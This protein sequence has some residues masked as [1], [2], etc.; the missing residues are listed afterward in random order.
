MQAK[1]LTGQRFG[2]LVAIRPTKARSNGHIKWECRCDCGKTACIS[3]QDLVRGSTRSC[4]CIRREHASTLSTA[5]RD[6]IAEKQMQWIMQSHRRKNNTSGKCGVRIRQTK[7]GPRYLAELTFEGKR[8]F[9]KT[10]RTF[11]EAVAARERAEKEAYA[12][13]DRTVGESK[14]RPAGVHADPAPG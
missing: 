13:Y 12:D 11:D 1:D 6:E 14:K 7:S 10:Y 4:G 3:A 5:Y 2:K 9:S 8:R